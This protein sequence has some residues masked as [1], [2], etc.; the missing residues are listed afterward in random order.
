V[1]LKELGGKNKEWVEMS[2]IVREG[3]WEDNNWA[4]V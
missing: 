4:L 2:G 3:V 1:G